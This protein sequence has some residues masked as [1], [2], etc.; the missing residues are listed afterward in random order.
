M[1]RFVILIIAAAFCC[2]ISVA[3]DEPIPPK[4][5]RMAKVGVFGGFTPGLLF[6]DAKPINAFL[7]GGKGAALSENG[8]FL[9]GGAGAA[10]IM[11]VPNFRVGGIGMNGSTSSTSLDATGIRRDA[12][13]KVGYGGVTLEYVIPIVERFDFAVGA[14]LGVGG[15]DIT[16][17]QSNGGSSTWQSEQDFFK[18]GLGAPG[19]LLGAPSNNTTRVLSGKFFVVIPSASF[20]YVVLPWM[21]LRLGVSYVGMIAPSWQVDGKYELLGVPGEVSGKG[22]M[23][24]GGLLVGFF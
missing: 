13:L 11:V 7:V 22:L 3:Q 16:I 9:F 21:A 18:S 14:M 6:L 23:I 15:I 24:N 20:E 10:Y 2:S 1:R 12:E 8:V 4:R 17:R 19:S 5:S